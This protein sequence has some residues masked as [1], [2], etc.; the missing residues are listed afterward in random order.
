MF[1]ELLVLGTRGI[2]HPS[3]PS[4]EADISISARPKLF[5][6]CAELD[7]LA[8][9]QG[10]EEERERSRSVSVAASAREGTPLVGRGRAPSSVAGSVASESR[11]MKR[12]REVSVT[13]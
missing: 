12:G 11:G 3:Q 5:D 13:A 2:V 7:K 9:E 4:A 1:F 10:A 6:V 8:L